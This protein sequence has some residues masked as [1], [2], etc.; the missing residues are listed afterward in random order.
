MLESV[1]KFNQ[2]R[3]KTGLQGVNQ[4][5]ITVSKQTIHELPSKLLS[6]IEGKHDR[7]KISLNPTRQLSGVLLW[8]SSTLGGNGEC[9]DAQYATP[10]I[11]ESSN[12]GVEMVKVKEPGVGQLASE[13][14]KRWKEREKRTEQKI[15]EKDRQYDK[16]MERK[17]KKQHKTRKESRI[18]ASQREETRR[19][20]KQE[21][22]KN[23]TTVVEEKT[24]RKTDQR[25]TEKEKEGQKHESMEWCLHGWK[26]GRRLA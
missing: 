25:T 19:N 4:K 7:R 5:I 23:R 21:K 12:G 2:E 15:T 20:T 6:F 8:C 1:W 18:F 3:S 9:C 26:D 16:D 22:K 24:P 11:T 13:W 14:V 10:A 17:E